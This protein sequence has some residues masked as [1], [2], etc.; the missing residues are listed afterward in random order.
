MNGVTEEVKE[1]ASSDEGNETNKGKWA[2]WGG[3]GVFTSHVIGNVFH[4]N[5]AE[6]NINGNEG[7]LSNENEKFSEHFG[8]G[9][10]HGVL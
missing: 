2:G 8:P 6:S 10:L 5:I 3:D 7:E 4:G 1:N 9:E